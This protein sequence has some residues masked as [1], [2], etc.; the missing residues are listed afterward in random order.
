MLPTQKG[1][2]FRSL[3][4]RSLHYSLLSRWQPQTLSFL[5]DWKLNQCLLRQNINEFI[6]PIIGPSV[7]SVLP[8]YYIDNSKMPSATLHKIAMP[9]LQQ[10]NSF[11]VYM[12]LLR[13]FTCSKSP[14]KDSSCTIF[15]WRSV[16]LD[17]FSVMESVLKQSVSNRKYFNAILF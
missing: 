11:I 1:V 8:F 17:S 14:Q 2:D 12:G 9:I 4:A 6:Y 16:L 15:L 13:N 3:N 7:N 5:S 10:K